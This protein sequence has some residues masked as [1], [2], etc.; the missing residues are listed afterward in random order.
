MAIVINKRNVRVLVITNLLLVLVFLVIRNSSTS[1]GES[2]VNYHPG[3]LVTFDESGNAPGTP[4]SVHGSVA[5]KQDKEVDEV[6]ENSKEVKFDAAT[7]YETILKQSHM[8]VFSKSY[9]PFSKKLKNLL[10]ESYKFS[11]SYHVVEL[12]Q[13]GHTDEL[14]D[15]IEKVTGRRTVPNVIINGVSKGGCDDMVTLHK[16]DK[17]LESL[18]EWSNGAFTVEAV[19]PSES[20]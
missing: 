13:H 11:P 19:P 1:A 20:T 2:G 5:N 12:D 9:C 4:E 6:N 16:E 18:K 10:A 15:Y 8:V 14:Q 17:L 7:E 3:S